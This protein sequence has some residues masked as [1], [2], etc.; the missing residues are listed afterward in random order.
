MHVEYSGKSYLITASNLIRDIRLD[1]DFSLDKVN[2]IESYFLIKFNVNTSQV[3]LD[4]MSGMFLDMIKG[5]YTS[6]KLMCF[7]DIYTSRSMPMG[8]INSQYVCK[9]IKARIGTRIGNDINFYKTFFEEDWELAKSKYVQPNL[10]DFKVWISKGYSKADAIIEVE[11]LKNK[12]SGS[13]DR[14]VEKYGIELGTKKYKSF[15]EKCGFRNTVEGKI[16]LYGLELGQQK[17]TEEN[18]KRSFSG[19][20]E[21]H[22]L[23]GTLD[24][25]NKAN[26]NRSKKNTFEYMVRNVGLEEAMRVCESKGWKHEQYVSKY[27]EEKAK[28]ILYNK[29]I[30]F[31]RENAIKEHGIV[32]ADAFLIKKLK[33]NRARFLKNSFGPRVSKEST[34]YLGILYNFLQENGFNDKDVLW[35]KTEKVIYL[36]EN[37]FAKRRYYDFCV[38]K[39]KIIIEYNGSAFHVDKEKL[40]EH[41]FNNWVSPWGTSAEMSYSYDKVKKELA[42]SHGYDVYYI[43]DKSAGKDVINLIEILRKKIENLKNLTR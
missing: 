11:K 12:T 9:V 17:Y 29:T 40:S 31:I 32:A 4:S 42:E 27:G 24:I 30:W 2:F 37:S 22:E 18:E 7:F 6:G 28:D 26:E 10:Y 39:L 36:T 35:G 41:D 5:K 8:R 34:K 13:L 3:S 14:F 15:G 21:G 1:P 25:Y 16:D 23:K 38:E 19:S 43:W 33:G 20:K